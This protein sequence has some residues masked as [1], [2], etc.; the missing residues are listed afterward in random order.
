MIYF[1]SDAHLGSKAFGDVYEHERKLI[2]LLNSFKKDAT[3]VY[4]LGDIFDFW[5]EY[6]WQDKSKKQFS[7]LMQTLRHMVKRGIHV[8]FFTGN[9]DLWTFGGLHKMTGM[10][11]H[12]HPYKVEHCGKRIYMAHGDG[13]V[14]PMMSED[15]ERGI[16][17][18]AWSA[19]PDK[20]WR[21]I[22]RF[23]RLRRVFHNHTAQR[24]FHYLPPKLGNALGYGW[25]KKSRLKEMKNPCPYKGEDKEELV[26]FAKEY[27]QLAHNEIHQVI[28]NQKFKEYH[29]HD[30][31]IFGHRHIALDLPITS[32][33]RVVMLGD[34][35]QQ[36]TYAKMNSKGELTLCTAENNN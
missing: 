11:I 20:D 21:R 5:Y 33:S 36:W 18:A 29:H 6:H 7:A 4:L 10:T 28:G 1:L 2:Q 17:P 15:V 34:C 3:Y 24:L 19:M 13:L 22:K 14:P 16:R 8:H 30:Y 32:D 12:H 23:I 9:H 26:L 35:F 25:A 27:E 31:Y